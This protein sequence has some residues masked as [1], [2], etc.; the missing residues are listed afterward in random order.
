MRTAESAWDAG[1]MDFFQ[2]FFSHSE[3][4]SIF[5]FRLQGGLCVLQL[6][7]VI[8]MHWFWC[9]C[10]PFEKEINNNKYTYDNENLPDIRNP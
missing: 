10:T 1:K 6:L 5:A 7:Y 2:T 8:D 4:S 3:K 9:S